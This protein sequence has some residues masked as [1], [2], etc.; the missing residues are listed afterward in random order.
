MSIDSATERYRRRRRWP[1][2]I[3]LLVLFVAA[4]IVW[5]QV[6]KPPPAQ[7]TGCNQPGP[8]PTS[9]SQT[10]RSVPSG[11]GA[12]SAGSAS[13]S[14]TAK[15]SGSASGPATASSSTS[16]AT[17]TVTT[18]LGKFVSHNTLVATRPATPRN[19]ALQ[20]YNA[21]EVR[22]MARTVTADLQNAGF[23]SIKKAADDVLYPGQDL[24]C[25][26]MIRFGPAGAAQARTVLIVAPCAQLVED[27]RIDESVDLAIGKLYDYQPATKEMIAQ[28]KA[29]NDAA[30]APAVIEGQ[31]VS[32]TRPLASIPPLPQADC[33]PAR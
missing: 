33:N 14:S 28:L 21:S 25:Q 32:F 15:T 22:G 29:L 5:F 4:G 17:P 27:N 20:V 16:S 9:S 8:A 7:A 6:L 24:I 10:T 19:I 18:T 13:R 30:N 12:S 26:E 23:E 1:I 31:T 11:S 2:T 3:V